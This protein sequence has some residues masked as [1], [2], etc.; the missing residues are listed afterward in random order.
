MQTSFDT[1]KASNPNKKA[2]RDEKLPDYVSY[3][4]LGSEL[5]K[6]KGNNNFHQRTRSSSRKERMWRMYLSKGS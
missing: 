2:S 6:T 3:G 5:Y 4:N 1:N